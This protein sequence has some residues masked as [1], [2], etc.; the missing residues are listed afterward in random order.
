MHCECEHR[1]FC[2][3]SECGMWGGEEGAAGGYI[4][5]HQPWGWGGGRRRAPRLLS[6]PLRRGEWS[7]R[8][9]LRRWHLGEASNDEEALRQRSE[10]G[11]F[12]ARED[13]NTWDRNECGV[14]LEQSPGLCVAG[15]R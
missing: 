2:V 14:C 7:G 10:G 13:Q 8:A 5:S 4:S 12:Q 9:S 11:A 3:H 15:V 6:W 1:V